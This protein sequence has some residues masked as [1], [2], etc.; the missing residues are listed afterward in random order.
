MIERGEQQR[1]CGTY[2]PCQPSNRIKSTRSDSKMVRSADTSEDCS[3]PQWIS[4]DSVQR[5]KPFQQNQKFLAA[6]PRPPF[7]FPIYRLSRKAD[8]SKMS[9]VSPVQP[10]TQCTRSRFVPPHEIN[11]TVRMKLTLLHSDATLNRT[12]SNTKTPAPNP[13]T[14]TATKIRLFT[15]N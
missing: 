1:I 2:S 3:L 10:K 14:S 15:D 5:K 7:V 11:P 12:T 4:S 8:P 6:F 9:P 13:T